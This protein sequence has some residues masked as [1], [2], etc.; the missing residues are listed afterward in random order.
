MRTIKTPIGVA[1]VND[2]YREL[3]IG[4]G[5][6]RVKDLRLPTA[7]EIRRF[8]GGQPMR[9]G[10]APANVKRY[11]TEFQNL[12]T[13]DI[14][15]SHKPDVVFDL[16][17]LRYSMMR[18]RAQL[19]YPDAP[20]Y[21]CSEETRAAYHT[22]FDNVKTWNDASYMEESYYDE[23]HAYEVLEHCGSQGD[24]RLFFAQF[25]EFWRILKPGG[26]FFATC[27]AWHSPWAWG[28]PSHSRVLTA[29]TLAFLSQ[30][31]YAKQ[32]GVTPMSDFRSIY[33]ADFE[34]VMVD[35]STE[36]LLFVLRAVK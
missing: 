35:E 20:H 5:S 30:E 23:I 13:L 25:S 15:A 34:P 17:E 21:T 10:M 18:Y 31:Q 9:P 6:R 22:N 28:D 16:C 29:G 1:P 26:L 3:M 19:P 11:G 2:L 4:C 32:V 24:Y 36:S 12:F 33:K 7:E 27:P 14:E 8:L